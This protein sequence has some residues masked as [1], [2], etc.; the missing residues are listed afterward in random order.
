M[1]GGREPVTLGDNPTPEQAVRIGFLLAELQS[2]EGWRVFEQLLE[3][4]RFRAA[5]VGLEDDDPKRGAPFYRGMLHAI[6]VVREGVKLFT[7]AYQE[8]KQAEAQDREAKKRVVGKG[9]GSLA[10]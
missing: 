9:E 8:S 7:L 4:T 3:R 5:I 6:D 10:L 1:T 2:L